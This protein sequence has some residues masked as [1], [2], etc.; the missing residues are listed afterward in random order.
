MNRGIIFYALDGYKQDYAGRKIDFVSE[1]EF[2]VRY[3]MK[4]NLPISIMTDHVTNFDESKFDKILRVDGTKFKNKNGFAIKTHVYEMSPYESTLL[5]DSDALV[6]DSD[7]KFGFDMSEAHGLCLCFD[8]AYHLPDYK[9]CLNDL[10]QLGFKDEYLLHYN[11]GVIFFNK[12]P[13]MSQF[14]AILKNVVCYNDNII[15]QTALSF[16]ITKQKINPF[17]LPYTWNYRPHYSHVFPH[18]P[19]KIWHSREVLPDEESSAFFNCR[20]SEMRNQLF[21]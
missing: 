15:P 7:L 11:G 14:F 20:N 9:H 16:L 13:I 12:T 3:A 6:V 19:I 10:K 8:I 2:A 4:T 21:I 18:G 17:V 5:L 1:V